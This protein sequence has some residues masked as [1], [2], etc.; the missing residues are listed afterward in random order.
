MAAVR[1][2][3]ELD[4]SEGFHDSFAVF[5]KEEDAWIVRRLDFRWRKKAGMMGMQATIRPMA[6]SAMLKYVFVSKGW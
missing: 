5:D 3:S 1:Y 2:E 4:P 6:C